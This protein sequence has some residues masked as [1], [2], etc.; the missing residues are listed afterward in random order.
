GG[1]EA[2]RVPGSSP[3][4]TRGEVGACGRGPS[5]T[6]RGSHLKSLHRNDLPDGTAL[7]PRVRPWDD[8]FYVPR[9]VRQAQGTPHPT[10][11]RRPTFSFKGRRVARGGASRRNSSAPSRTPSPL[12]G[13]GGREAVG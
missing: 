12:E 8:D 3:R 6:I 9:L 4:T 2:S 13:E 1:V 10:R 11:L 5:L 7:T